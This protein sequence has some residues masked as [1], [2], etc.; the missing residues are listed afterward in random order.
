MYEAKDYRSVRMCVCVR[1]CV[2]AC[3]CVSMGVGARTCVSVCMSMNVVYGYMYMGVCCVCVN[4]CTLMHIYGVYT[5]IKPTRVA[6][7]PL[8]M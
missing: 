7:H 1:A 4:V 6:P 3:V 2:R 8:H 5:F